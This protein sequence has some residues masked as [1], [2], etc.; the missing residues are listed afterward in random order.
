M[1]FKGINLS[2][3][4]IDSLSKANYFSPSSVQLKVIPRALKGETLLVQSATGTGKTHAFL[5]PIIERLDLSNNYVQALVI[6]P[7]RELARQIY[8]FA[9]YFEKDFAPLKVKLLIAGNELSKSKEGLS[10]AP[11]IIIAT[12]NRMLDIINENIIS[13]SNVKTLVLD[14]ADMLLKEGFFT[15]VDEITTHL[16][17]DL[18]FLVFSATLEN[19]IMNELSKF[20]G[21]NIKLIN[22]DILTNENVKHHLIDIKSL[23]IYEATDI[24]IKKIN[25]YLLLIFASKKET[26][27]DLYRYLI[28]QKYHVG[29]LTGDLS[30]RERKNVMKQL[31][32]DKINILVCSD[33]ASRGL[34]IP[35]VT[36]VL[37]VDLAP[38][39]EFYYHRAGRTGRFNN[40]GHCYTFYNNDNTKRVLDLIIDG[41]DFDYLQIKNQ[42]ILP[43]KPIEK[44][45]L[46]KRKVD[47]ELN[48]EIRKVTARAKGKEKKV[49]PG[50]KKKVKLEVEEVKRKH[51]REKIKKAI[52]KERVERY[53]R[54]AKK[55]E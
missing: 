36:E 13:L 23:S 30:S 53:K 44:K 8:T 17:K 52:R 27:N 28:S 2:P 14:E 15:E 29:V 16:N 50:Y 55:Y 49:K 33:V 12:P 3:K 38:N 19:N 1:S 47:E 24:F 42:E 41:V 6:A 51:R 37:N 18:Q 21:T 43:G 46:A 26:V 9:S 4:M 11:H 45:H 25:P 32:N 10:E 5:I 7:T 54:E 22:E 39:K 34:D 31:L 48:N 40:D 35:N 20:I